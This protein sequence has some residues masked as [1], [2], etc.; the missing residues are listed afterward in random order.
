MMDY[1]NLN[2]FHLEV[3]ECDRFKVASFWDKM[4][5]VCNFERIYLVKD[6]HAQLFLK[7]TVIDL[8]PNKLYFL[9]AYSV[10]SGKCI[11]I[12]DHYFV[13]FKFESNNNL[14]LNTLNPFKIVETTAYHET[15]FNELLTLVKN[16]N[17]TPSNLLHINGIMQIFLSCFIEPKNIDSANSIR[18]KQAISYIT[19]NIDKPL[20]IQEIANYLH[21]HP[22][23]FSNIFSSLTN[24]PPT[25][26]IISEKIKYATNLLINT[27]L[28]IKQIAYKIGYENEL[29]FSRLFKIKTGISPSNFRKKYF[30]HNNN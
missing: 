16:N 4:V 29:Y 12:M 3:V 5:S 2:S 13:H 14:L 21:L 22:I 8:K 6:G 27:N 19:K 26:Y 15:L 7:G 18:I 24:I 20:T 1:N 9:P 25:Q 10:L 30:A 17:N 11:E 28:P 23:Y